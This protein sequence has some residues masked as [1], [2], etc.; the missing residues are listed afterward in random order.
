[1]GL[2]GIFKDKEH[3]APSNNDRI[4]GLVRGF[5]AG[6]GLVVNVQGVDMEKTKTY[7]LITVHADIPYNLVGPKGI[8]SKDLSA[9]ISRE[10]DE[11]I[12]LNVV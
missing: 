3:V 11:R 6:R 2:F 5:A 10:L 1:M 4:I 9:F 7:V 12:K 8:H